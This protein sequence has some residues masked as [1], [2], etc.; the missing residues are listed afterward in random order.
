[1]LGWLLSWSSLSLSLMAWTI[2]TPTITRPGRR[3]LIEHTCGTWASGLLRAQ[4]HLICRL[5]GMHICNSPSSCSFGPAERLRV[6][7]CACIIY[8]TDGS[9]C[10]RCPLPLYQC[11]VLWWSLPLWEFQVMGRD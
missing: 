11:S 8:I 3:Y 9:R 10:S 1:M 7:L 5:H 2:L 6:T 4:A